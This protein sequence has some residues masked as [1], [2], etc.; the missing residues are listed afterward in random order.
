MPSEGLLRDATEK[1]LLSRRI[2]FWEG[3]P[4]KEADDGRGRKFCKLLHVRDE[5]V[6][7]RRREMRVLLRGA[8]RAER[9][10]LSCAALFSPYKFA[11]CLLESRDA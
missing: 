4:G 7:S 3:E 8:S 1:S 5:Q 6:R 2:E 11:A 9:V 10:T